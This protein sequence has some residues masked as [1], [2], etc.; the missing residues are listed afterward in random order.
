M[1]DSSEAYTTFCSVTRFLFSANPNRFN[2]SDK[3]AESQFEDHF[4]PSLSQ[5]RTEYS[6]GIAADYQFLCPPL[7]TTLR[8]PFHVPGSCPVI[9]HSLSGLSRRRLRTC[10]S[11][12]WEAVP[13]LTWS[14]WCHRS[15]HPVLHMQHSISDKRCIPTFWTQSL[16]SCSVLRRPVPWQTLF[17]AVLRR[18]CIP[19]CL[20][21][22][23][24]RQ[25]DFCSTWE[26]SQP[27]LCPEFLNVF[28]QLVLI[29]PL[30]YKPDSAVKQSIR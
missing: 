17:S 23:I 11:D 19:L 26:I 10:S 16:S 3:R 7:L 21:G 12:A 18:L 29:P 8:N 5:K 1:E 13:R 2:T 15:C 9:P 24:Q 20:S 30:T 6:M 27:I 25:P 28:F 14:L 4:Q 22:Y